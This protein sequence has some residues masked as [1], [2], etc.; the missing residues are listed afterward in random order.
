MAIADNLENDTARTEN[1]VDV[2]IITAL[3][4][5]RDAV[6]RLVPLHRPV[7]ED[8]FLTYYRAALE[9]DA[10]SGRKNVEVAVTM[11]RHVGN[12]FAAVHTARCLQR[13]KPHYVLMVGIGGGVKEEVDLGDVVVAEQIIYYEATKENPFFSDQRPHA[14]PADGLLLDRAKNYTDIR[15][16]ALIQAERP[17]SINFVNVPEVRFG[18]IASGEKV[19]ADENRVNELK[20]VHSKVCGL[21]MESFGVALAASEWPH[22]PKFIAFR[23]FAIMLT[24]KKM[25]IGMN[26][27]RIAQRHLR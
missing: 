20:Q 23:G 13:L 24:M 26:T 10:E 16:H 3:P 21:D 2:L 1:C 15:W 27:L 9:T 17:A 5:E 8:N 4:V 12:V 22:S 18:P 6:L 25:M 14:I 19:I 7:Q 11:L